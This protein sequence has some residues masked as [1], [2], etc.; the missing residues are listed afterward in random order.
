ML[1]WFVRIYS[2]S[3][4]DFDLGKMNRFSFFNTSDYLFTVFFNDGTLW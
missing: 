2:L 1:V 3:F 4:N